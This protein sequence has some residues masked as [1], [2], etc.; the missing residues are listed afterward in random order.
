MPSPRHE[1]LHRRRF[2]WRRLSKEA[3]RRALR[4]FFLLSPRFLLLLILLLLMLLLLLL[5]LL[6][7][8]LLLVTANRRGERVGWKGR[9]DKQRI[10]RLITGADPGREEP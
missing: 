6:L 3:P 5:L 1:V 2:L 9:C 10:P 4:C 8:F 7:L